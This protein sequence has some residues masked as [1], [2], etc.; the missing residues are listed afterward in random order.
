MRLYLVRHPRPAV[1]EG[2]CY[3][4][5]DLDLAED[6]AAVAAVLRPQLPAGLPLF[7]S[8]LRRCRQLAAALHPAPVLD[9]RLLE[10]DFGAWEMRPWKALDRAA[11]DAWAAQPLDFAP[12][13]GE[14]P[15]QLLQRAREFLAGLESDAIVVTHAGVI[16][17]LSG[18]LYGLPPAE[19]IGLSFD[20]GSLIVLNT[21]QWV[22]LGRCDSYRVSKSNLI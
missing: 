9:P 7:S 15:A 20:Y 12:P 5:T 1:A 10:M 16:K 22:R 13:G 17:A 14:S 4:R 11:L 19:W 8:P 3:G 6:A 2:I 18:L 21:G